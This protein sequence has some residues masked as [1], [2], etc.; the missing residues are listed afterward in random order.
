MLLESK[1]CYV[2]IFSRKQSV[3]IYRV[4]QKKN[5]K[6]PLFYKVANIISVKMLHN[7]L[8]STLCKLSNAKKSFQYNT[9][10]WRY[11]QNDISTGFPFWPWHYMFILKLTE[12]YW[13]A[14]PSTWLRW[15]G[16]Q[17]CAMVIIADTAFR[18][19]R[20]L[21]YAYKLSLIRAGEQ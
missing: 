16:M 3:F 8:K 19:I 2:A 21:H 5:T 7:Y 17:V 11:V 12:Y 4:S 18:T 14:L 6:R 15:F 10:L 1:G 9:Y 20:I 13:A